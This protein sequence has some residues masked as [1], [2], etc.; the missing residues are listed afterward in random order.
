MITVQFHLK[1]YREN[2]LKQAF[3]SLEKLYSKLMPNKDM[4]VIYHESRKEKKSLTVIRSPHVHKK[5]REQF[6]LYS[7]HSIF[8]VEVSDLNILIYILKT[9]SFYGVQIKVTVQSRSFLVL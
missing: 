6:A 2:L 7:Y 1:S 5:S 9:C 8:T 4:R 3:L